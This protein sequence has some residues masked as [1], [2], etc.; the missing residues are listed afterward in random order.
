MFNISQIEQYRKPHPFGFPHKS[1]DD[2]GWFIIP[3]PKGIQLFCMSSGWVDQ[4]WYHVSIST[5]CNRTPNWSEM[6]MI[7]DMFFG[8]VTVV[9]FHP[10]KKDYVNNAKNCLHLWHYLKGEFPVPQSILV[11][12]K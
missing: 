9:Q 3:S 2:F 6:C 5:N 8:D 11:G 4:D 7:K 1:G 10:L 12:I